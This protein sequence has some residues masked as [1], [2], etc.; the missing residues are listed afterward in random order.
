[1]GFSVEGLGFRVQGFGCGV[2]SFLFRVSGSGFRVL[3][4]GFRV[5][6]SGFRVSGFGSMGHLRVRGKRGSQVARLKLLRRGR[7]WSHWLGHWSHWR[8][9]GD[10]RHRARLVRASGFQGYLAY[11]KPPPP[12]TYGGPRGR[13]F[14]YERGTPCRPQNTIS[15]STPDYG[16]DLSHFQG[17]SV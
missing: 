8:G 16:L 5:L 14:S 1:M 7:H 15:Q 10:S 9:R 2:S 17:Q 13:A 3:C 11:K 6:G 4:F 12:W